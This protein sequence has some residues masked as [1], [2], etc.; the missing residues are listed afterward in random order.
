MLLTINVVGNADLKRYWLQCE[1]LIAKG[2][3]VGGGGESSAAHILEDITNQRAYLVV[4]EDASGVVKFASAVQFIHYPN[5]V[6]ASVYAVGGR[7]VIDNAQHWSHVKAW[8]KQ[9]GASKVQGICKP[10]QARLWK[11]LGFKPVYQTMR[12]DL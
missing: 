6:V 8:M 2:L 9:L 3:A 7:G 12:E 11:K 5:Y 10:A 4:G 1:P